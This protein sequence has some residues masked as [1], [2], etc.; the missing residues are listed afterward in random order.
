MLLAN[1]VPKGTEGD[2][3]EQRKQS[4][5]SIVKVVQTLGIEQ[6]SKE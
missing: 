3:A 6:I 4:A 1:I 5:R 2:D